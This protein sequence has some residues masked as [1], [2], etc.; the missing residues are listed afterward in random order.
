MRWKLQNMSTLIFMHIP[1]TAGRSF[2]TLL[3]RQYPADSIFE[4][5]GYDDA[6]PAAAARL[7][8][9]DAAEKARIRLIRG[10]YAFGLHQH[11]DQP[12]TY[13]TFLRDPVERVISLYHYLLRDGAHPLHDWLLR[14]R[15]S[16][17]AFAGNAAMSH[18][19]NVQAQYLSGL[20]E[21]Y[22]AA[23]PDPALLPLAVQNMQEHCVVGLVEEF[24]RSLM[25]M[26]KQFGWRHVTYERRNVT[27]GRVR[28][29]T[30]PGRVV[31]LIQERNQLDIALYE[32]AKEQFARS[33]E[34]YG[35]GLDAAVVRMRILNI[36]DGVARRLRAR[37]HFR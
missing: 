10:H 8:S 31:D 2:S 28:T 30:L 4:L 9:M 37:L 12:A 13:I 14:E 17:E 35:S 25:V 34:A 29:S 15:I 22:N 33:L 19:T 32:I 26:A 11:L 36:G 23:N 16:L 21:E 6:I 7:K 5:Y 1:K 3:N 24:D 20:K 18:L 27:Q